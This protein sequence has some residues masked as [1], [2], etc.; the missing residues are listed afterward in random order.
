VLVNAFGPSVEADANDGVL[1][2]LH[3]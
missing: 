2:L 1:D 3:R